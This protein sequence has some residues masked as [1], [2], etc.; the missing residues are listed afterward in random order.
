MV[1]FP[2]A[3]QLAPP[4][5]TISTYRPVITE[6]SNVNDVPVAVYPGAN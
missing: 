4:L 5:A 1:I 3:V 6:K 2:N